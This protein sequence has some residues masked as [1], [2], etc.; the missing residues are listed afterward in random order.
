MEWGQSRISIPIGVKPIEFWLCYANSDGY[1]HLGS[2]DVIGSTDHMHS[3]AM[4]R[5]LLQYSNRQCNLQLF[6]WML[7][8][9]TSNISK[10]LQLLAT[11]T[12][13]SQQP[14]ATF[15]KDTP[16]VKT[17]RYGEDSPQRNHP[18][19]RRQLSEGG[20]PSP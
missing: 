9:Q 1:M 11:A 20:G 2:A 10:K 12:A 18:P 3:F 17:M 6:S 5:R 13:T 14:P 7:L 15:A 4:W 8:C 16:R 19:R